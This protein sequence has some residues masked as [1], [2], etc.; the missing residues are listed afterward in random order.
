MNRIYYLILVLIVS[1]FSLVKA[2]SKLFEDDFSSGSISTARWTDNGGFSYNNQDII[3]SVNRNNRTKYIESQTVTLRDVEN[4]L[5][6][7]EYRDNNTW[8]VTCT[9]SLTADGGSNYDI[10]LTYGLDNVDNTGN[11]IREVNLSSYVGQDINIRFEISYSGNNNNNRNWYLDDISIVGSSLSRV[12]DFSYSNLTSTSVDLSWDL[13]GN[14]DVLITM[15]DSELSGVLDDGSYSVSD[16]LDDGSTVVYIGNLETYQQTGIDANTWSYF[17]IWSYS[18]SG[19]GRKYSFSESIGVKALSANDELYEDFENGT[20]GWSLETG[21]SGTEWWIGSAVSYSGSNAAYVTTDNGATASYNVNRTNNI[22]LT[23]QVTLPSNYKSAE[24][25]F[26]WKATGEGGYDGGSVRINNTNI[27]NSKSLYGQDVWVERV[28][29]LTNQIGNTFNLT[30]RWENDW[31][32]GDNPGLCIDEVRITGSEVARPEV[33]NAVAN[34]A[35]EIALSWTKSIDDDDVIVAYSP[36]GAIGRPEGGTE[37]TAGDYF[38]EGG[39]VIYVGSATEYTHT[40]VFEGSLNYSIWSVSSGTVVYSSALTA[41]VQVPVALPYAEDFETGGNSWSFDNAGYLD[42]WVVGS[43]TS[44]EGTSSAYISTTKGITT[45]FDEDWAITYLDVEVD[46]RNYTTASVNFWWKCDGDGRDSYGQVFIDGWQ[47]SNDLDRNTTWREETLDLRNYVGSIRTLRFKWIDIGDN[48]NP[49][50]CVD[51]VYITGTIDDPDNFTASNN[52]V[53]LNNLSWDLSGYGDDVMVAWS[54]DGVFGDPVEGTIYEVGDEI[55][56]GG[57]ILSNGSETTYDH[58]P[59]KYGTIY[60]YKAWSTRNGIYSAGVTSSANTPAKVPVF[61]EDWESGGDASWVLTQTNTDTR[62][63]KNGLVDPYE[64]TYSAYITNDGTTPGYRKNRTRNAQLA[65]D[66][67]LETLQSASLSFAW[68]SNGENG[69]D[70]GEVWLGGSKITGSPQ[71]SGETT[72]QTAVV[73]L[74]AYCGVVGDQT[75]E[76]RWV[77]DNN[78]NGNNPGF[79]IDN[80]EVGGIYAATSIVDNSN[81]LA[82]SI[83]SVLN[84]SGTGISVFE[85][86][87]T[88]KASLYSDITR[89]QQLVI[90]KGA[91]N[92]IDDWSDVLGGALLFGPDIDAAGIEGVITSGA[93]TFTGTDFILLE[94]E[95]VAETY[96]LKVW[97]MPDINSLGVN[98]NDAFDF[99]VNSNNIVTGLGDDFVVDQLVESGAVTINVVATAIEII[100]QPSEYATIGEALAV[101]PRISA[102]DANGNIDLDFGSA[103]DL[104]SNGSLIMSPTSVVASSGI[105]TFSNLSF[106]GSDSETVY[107]TAS[108]SDW[109]NVISEEINIQK[110]CVPILA[111]DANLYISNVIINTINNTSSYSSN[112]YGI[113][114]DQEASLTVDVDYSISIGVYDADGNSN[115]TVWIDW[116]G[117]EVFEAGE[118][119]YTGSVSRSGVTVLEGTVNVASNVNLQYG[120]TRMRVQVIDGGNSNTACINSLA[121]EGESEDYIVIISGEGWLGQTNVWSRTQNWSSGAIPDGGTDVY[122]PEHPY[123]N[124]VFP[125]ISGTV[126]M[127]DLEIAENASLTISAGSKVNINGDVITNGGL[128]IKNTNVSPSSVITGGNVTGDV[129]VNWTYSSRRYWYIGHSVT[130]IDISDYDDAISGDNAYFL[131][132]YI[133]SWNVL[134]D[135]YS[136][137]DPMEGYSL[138]VK[139]EGTEFVHT[140][141]LNNNTSYSKTL[142]Y[143]WQLMANPYPSYY[144]LTVEDDITGDFRNTKGSVY[145]RTGDDWNSRYLATYNV[146][147]GITTPETFDGILAPGQ[148]FWV[149]KAANGDV[150]MNADKRIHGSAALKSSYR[151]QN[152]LRINLQNEF[153]SSESVV[154][155][156]DNGTFD[157]SKLD[158]KIRMESD[159]KLSYLYS[160]KSD[161][162]AVINVLPT[163]FDSCAIQIGFKAFCDGEHVLSVGGISTFDAE[164]EIILEDKVKGQFVDLRLTNNYTFTTNKGLCD[165]RFILHLL[166]GSFDAEDEVPTSISNKNNDVSVSCIKGD[167]YIK[168]NWEEQSKGVSLYNLNGQL[169]NSTSFTGTE[170]RM[171]WNKQGVYIIKVVGINQ[172]H[173]QKIFVE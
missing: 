148:S 41:E 135:P 67:N 53:L 155:L 103:I 140:G 20:N 101:V 74:S 112:G 55:V 88:D 28:V 79:C 116:D 105:A 158:S 51:N 44:Y 27:I 40:G 127:N 170:H 66:I 96:S 58:E 39:Q 16:V 149:E 85:F 75:L 45:D 166:I 107:L 4:Y 10:L 2:Q 151:N 26:F 60:Y 159:N 78:N 168:C 11:T 36:Y 31:Q 132:N 46:L 22:D 19:S 144:Q 1:S 92:E 167:I 145:V 50:F 150:F 14:S 13:N 7:K 24:L 119:V 133:G 17:R 82:T 35:T 34:S 64:G 59:L 110:Y 69:R 100:Q 154:A 113:Y 163:E 99:A 109:D 52:N 142:S 91:A 153:T 93:I 143:G 15:A 33:F 108:Y 138:I 6:F 131:Y 57:T 43:A 54:S 42:E 102:V 73:D 125:I 97:L 95:G 3:G 137:S 65:I 165:D 147:T 12:L 18:G 152:T 89:I 169:I 21:N 86:D 84:D 62:W 47:V 156:R 9:V 76:F 104:V 30:F 72:W 122:I 171:E 71:Y 98:D 81:R 162:K 90:S 128:V 114:L 136:F 29:D 124:D 77:N 118:E 130:G 161:N 56:G 126:S 68:K 160:L 61:S 70:Y 117:D 141:E 146:L 172:I 121:T 164:K 111:G 173:T 8:G 25:S 49:G 134:S 129:T 120:A 37:Y 48:G 32:D 139:N 157:F 106:T 23:K 83:S 63:I 115:V 87:L 94:Q 80:I 5:Y 38:S 123:Y